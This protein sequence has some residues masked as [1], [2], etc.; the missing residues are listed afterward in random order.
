MSYVIRPAR[1]SDADDLG[2]VHVRAWQA[3]Y[4][5]GLM[6]DEYLDGLSVDDRAAMWR[7]GLAVEPP[8]RAAPWVAEAPG[9]TVVGFAV[10]GPSRDD[11]GDDPGGELHAINVDPDHWGTGAGE[12][13]FVAGVDA[14]RDAGFTDAIL[15]VH[16]D[17]ARARA[18]YERHGWDCDDVER[19]EDI[20]G[21]SVPE[22]R[23][24]ITW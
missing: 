1:L 5:G 13:L 12:A 10:V 2:R 6:P 11:D 15:W 24:S 4:T 3:A 8:P 17:N 22:I 23:Y 7:R 16:P 14:L 21:A 20:A 19:V 9:G 18:F